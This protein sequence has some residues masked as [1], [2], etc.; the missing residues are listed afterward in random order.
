MTHCDKYH[1][2]CAFLKLILLPLIAGILGVVMAANPCEAADDS[3]SLVLLPDTQYYSAKHPEIFLSQTRWIVERAKQDDIAAVIG[4]GDVVDNGNSLPQWQRAVSALSLLPEARIPY[5]LAIG[6]HDYG[7]ESGADPQQPRSATN[8][9]RFL[10]PTFY[11]DDLGYGQPMQPGSNE[12]FFGTIKAGGRDLLIMVLE[13]T[14]RQA[15]LDWAAHVIGAHPGHDVVIVTHAY[16]NS[17]STRITRCARYNKY[18]Y[19]LP[20]DNDGEEVWDKLVSR[21]PNIR[22]VVSGHVPEIGVARRFG[23]GPNGNLVNEVLSDFQNE[24]NGGNGWLRIMKVQPALNRVDVTTYSPYLAR[25]P[26]LKIAPWKRDGA[27]EF[28]LDYL[29]AGL[30]QAGTIHGVVRSGR[31]A[32]ACAPIAGAKVTFPGGETVTDANGSFVA[33]IRATAAGVPVE[34]HGLYEAV[35]IDVSKQGRVPLKYR[36]SVRDGADSPEQILLQ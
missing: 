18:G 35:E 28:S 29:N 26:E 33:V 9:N 12:N 10:G 5:F 31:A 2:M 27:N 32:D 13:F 15:A 11:R 7:P 1:H 20:R 36:A 30:F 34:P 8:F 21:Y 4:L 3:F 14:P 24:P 17:D 25:H 22:L 16:V 19:G 23:V 6:N